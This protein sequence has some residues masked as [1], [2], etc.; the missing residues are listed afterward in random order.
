[1]TGSKEADFVS[2]CE[3]N[4]ERGSEGKREGKKRDRNC[5]GTPSIYRQCGRELT[6]Q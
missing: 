6:E 2:V 4:R 3:R 5:Q 1:M